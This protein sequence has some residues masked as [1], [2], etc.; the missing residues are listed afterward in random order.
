MSSKLLHEKYIT[1]PNCGLEVRK[2]RRNQKR[3]GRLKCRQAAYWANH[4]RISVPG[5]GQVRGNRGSDGR[6]R[7]PRVR[8]RRKGV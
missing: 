8:K 1:C 4:P 3:C 5:Y 2:K 7:F 6:Y